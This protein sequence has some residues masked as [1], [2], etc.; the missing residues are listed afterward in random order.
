MEVL[1]LDSLGQKLLLLCR[2]GEGVQGG[3]VPKIAWG[4]AWSLGQN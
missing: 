2:S 4:T 1:S 3:S